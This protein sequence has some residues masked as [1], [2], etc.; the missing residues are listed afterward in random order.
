MITPLH[1]RRGDRGE[2][3]GEEAQKSPPFSQEALLK[4]VFSS[5]IL[6]LPGK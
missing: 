1:W 5:F 6:Q 2:E 4:N 3:A